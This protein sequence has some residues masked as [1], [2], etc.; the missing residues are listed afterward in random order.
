MGRRRIEKGTRKGFGG[1]KSNGRIKPCRPPGAHPGEGE[2]MFCPYCGSDW[3][4]NVYADDRHGNSGDASECLSCGEFFDFD[5]PVQPDY[6]S[7]DDIG[8][9]DYDGDGI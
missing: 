2:M 5:T 9:T 1:K 4:R 6:P 7:S 3:V 8:E